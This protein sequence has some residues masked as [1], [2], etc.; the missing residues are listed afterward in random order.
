MKQHHTFANSGTDLK[1][2][3]CFKMS[4]LFSAAFVGLSLSLPAPSTASW[5]SVVTG[6]PV[7]ALEVSSFSGTLFVVLP[8][9][10]MASRFE[11][12]SSK[13]IDSNLPVH[14]FRNP[15]YKNV[16]AEIHQIFK[17]ILRTYPG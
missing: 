6:A 12:K 13:M 14:F 17:N 2:D 5:P 4:S 16:Q 15:F 9:S 1:N 3:I 10:S 11:S 8:D 7:S